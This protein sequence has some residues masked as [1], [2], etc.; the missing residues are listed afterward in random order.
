MA[1][2]AHLDKLNAAQR[3]AVTHGEPLPE[4][5]FA[6]GPLLILAGAGTGKTDTLAHRVAHLVIHGVDPARI[7][8]LTFTR[9]AAHEMRRRA[10]EITK[11]A[12]KESMGGVS[13][14]ISQRLAWAGTFHSIGNRLL[15]HYAG[16]LQLDP[17]F[18]VIDR[19]DSADLM[20][21]LRAE[22]GLAARDQRF[23]R[24]D[25]C[26]AI[27]S[28]RV[29]TRA[30]LKETLERHYPWCLQW[31]TELT[32]L[33]RGYVEQKQHAHLLDYDDLLLY[34]HGMMSEARLAQHIGAHF[35]HVLVDEYQDTNRLQAEIL[36]ALKPDGAGLT[37]VGDDAQAI[38][39]FRAAAVENIL[40]FAQRFQPRAEVVALAQN[41]RSTQQVLD[42]ANA[43]MGE[44]PREQR[45]Y[46]LSV[47]GQGTRPRAVTVD[48]LQTQA[49]YV[50]T[51]VLRR[52]EANVPLR[53]Q[54]VLF[55]SASHS[56]VLEVE[57]TKHKIPYVKYGGLR[58]LEAAHVKDLLAVL[59]WAD[60]PRN[61]LA[62]FR[63]LQL[64]PGMGP[65][66]AAAAIEHM[67]TGGNTFEALAGFKPPQTH[68]IDWRRLIELLRALADPQLPWAGQVHQAREWYQKHFERIYEH[69]HTRLGDLDQLEHLSG[70]YPS[71]ERFITELTLDPPHATSD[72]AGRPSLEEDYLVLST[73]H[74][75]KGMEWDTVY[76]LN[77]VDGSFP[78]EFSTG[79]P[80]LIEEERRLLYVALTRA[81][82]DLALVMPLKFHL[83]QQSRQG[84]AHVYGG[85]SRFM[86][87][88]VLKTLDAAI[89]QG[90]SRLGEDALQGTG[91]QQLT[92]DVGARLRDMW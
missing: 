71:R 59:R 45:K 36:H 2:T 75:A 74:S 26:L 87:E 27:Y 28:N 61:S 13:A 30:P 55:R 54:A 34:W 21:S 32:A 53:R 47:R 14:T 82:N 92:V 23:P 90:S 4:K 88:K 48:E 20:D 38:Y 60:N 51:E 65:V 46:L 31:E 22:L 52:R 15:R 35:D 42:V 43:V 8:M 78:S 70:Q 79:R 66:N 76:L 33:F 62:A 39:S 91:E 50:R 57:L 1:T 67:E 89:F 24:K 86:T 49:E 6:S 44:A 12:L 25:T 3:K 83:T 77:V 10:H 58:F 29:N 72:L 7:L 69:F 9:R 5:G 68:E 37:V 40:G 73:I 63:V 81:Q 85:R 56:D 19:G 80:E 11:Q 16:H 64:L 41:Y 18:S 84:D 17:H